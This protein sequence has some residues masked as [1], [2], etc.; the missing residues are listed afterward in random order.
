ML[1]MLQSNLQSKL[2]VSSHR[3]KKTSWHLE[4]CWLNVQNLTDGVSQVNK[5]TS[6]DWNTD[7]EGRTARMAAFTLTQCQANDW[8]D[9]SIYIKIYLLLRL[10]FLLCSQVCISF[11]FFYYF[12]PL[13]FSCPFFANG[14]RPSVTLRDFSMTSPSSTSTASPKPTTPRFKLH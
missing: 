10:S 4:Y 3:N 5:N 9:W 7:W 11:C 13:W 2:N 14:F 6:A 1:G 8:S 12:F